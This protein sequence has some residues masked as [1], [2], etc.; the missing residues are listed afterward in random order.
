MGSVSGFMQPGELIAESID[1][2][3]LL[4]NMQQL[5]TA[6]YITWREKSSLLHLMLRRERRVWP[7]SK[8]RVNTWGYLNRY[9]LK[10][11]VMHR[12]WRVVHTADASVSCLGDLLH[13]DAA[14]FASAY[15]FHDLCSHVPI[16]RILLLSHCKSNCLHS[17]AAKK[18]F[19]YC[20]LFILHRSR[21]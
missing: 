9:F 7:M 19:N 17:T 3:P 21:D 15:L 6:L 12:A 18:K 1:L 11:A 13:Y 16:F 2:A 10:I 14:L 8:Y 20:R 5:F 4:C